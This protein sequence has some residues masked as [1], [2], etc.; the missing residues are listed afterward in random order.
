MN[1]IVN[2]ISSNFT[3]GD[4]EK[5]K[6]IEKNKKTDTCQELKNIAYKTMLL[7]GHNIIP[8]IEENNNS[9]ITSYLETES[10][11]NKSETWI[12]LDKTQKIMRLNIY[13]DTLVEQYKLNAAELSGLKDYFIKCLERKNLL[14]TK[15]ITYNKELNII[16]NVPYLIFSEENRRFILKKDDKHVSTVKSLPSDKKGKAK[17]I[18]IHE[19][20]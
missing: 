11:N 20:P 18:K 2:D 3:I 12:K 9:K 19:L 6:Q 7:K 14:R 16:D 15:E 5:R 4:I 17:T 1:I 8:T 13:A 10:K